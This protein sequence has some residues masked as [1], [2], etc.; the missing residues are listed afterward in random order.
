MVF[1][2]AKMP[3]SLSL[4]FLLL[5]VYI[6]CTIFTTRWRVLAVFTGSTIDCTHT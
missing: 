1:E 4:L 3:L 2:G 5:C 6:I